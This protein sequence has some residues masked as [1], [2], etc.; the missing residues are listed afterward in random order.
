MTL[1]SAP[2]SEWSPYL[3]LLLAGAVPTQMWR[4][5]GTILSRS[6]NEDSEILQ[7]VKAVATALVAGLIAN[8]VIFPVGG[9]AVV[10]LW[11][12][13]LALLG[14]YAVYYKTRPRIIFG[15][16]AAEA[17]LIVMTLIFT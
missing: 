9:L 7:W 4:W 15:I 17:M 3:F 10:P 16:V 5:I 11:A 2:F 12:R 8:L 1:L 6:I 14:G 13:I